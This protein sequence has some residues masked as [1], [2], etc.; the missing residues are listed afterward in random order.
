MK[1]ARLAGFQ[2]LKKSPWYVYG[3]P[4]ARLIPALPFVW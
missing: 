3:A 2:A 1:P 4:E